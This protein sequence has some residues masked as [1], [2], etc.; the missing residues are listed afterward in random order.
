MQLLTLPSFAIDASFASLIIFTA[1][2]CS[3]IIDAAFIPARHFPCRRFEPFA[4]YAFRFVDIFA[5][6]YERRASRPPAASRRHSLPP[7]ATL[8]LPA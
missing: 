5:M 8:A 1:S 3:H 2:P 6:R 7:L 4:A